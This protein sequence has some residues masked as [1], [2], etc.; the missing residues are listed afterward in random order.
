MATHYIAKDGND[1]TSD[2]TNVSTPWATYAALVADGISTGD[3]VLFKAGTYD[4][5]I[6]YSRSGTTHWLRP[7]TVHNWGVYPTGATV[8]FQPG[9]DREIL[10]FQDG[11]ASDAMTMQGI[12]FKKTNGSHTCEASVARVEFLTGSGTDGAELL[13]DQC[14]FIANEDEDDLTD[15]ALTVKNSRNMKLTITD[16]EF[17]GYDRR[18]LNITHARALTT[19]SGNLF[20][21]S[22]ADA[23]ATNTPIQLQKANVSQDVKLDFC[24]NVVKFERNIVGTTTTRAALFKFFQT[25]YV[26]DNSFKATRLAG[27]AALSDDTM[28]RI[29]EIDTSTST[30]YV[31]DEVVVTGNTFINDVHRGSC[32]YLAGETAI[33][34]GT[35]TV[36]YNEFIGTEAYAVDSDARLLYLSRTVNTTVE[37]NKFSTANDGIH[38]VECI[39]TDNKVNNNYFFK[40]ED[41]G[42][43]QTGNTYPIA[44]WFNKCKKFTA[45]NNVFEYTRDTYGT[46]F[47]SQANT[48]DGDNAT[49][50][51]TNNRY[52]YTGPKQTVGK[53]FTGVET[54]TYDAD[55]VPTRSGEVYSLDGTANNAT[56]YSST[57]SGNKNLAALLAEENTGKGHLLSNL[58][59]DVNKWSYA[60]SLTNVF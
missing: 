58:T 16:N 10:F 8:V 4:S 38:A 14:K 19:I 23:D 31:S 6:N 17:Y 45:D 48:G 2:G 11:I 49:H 51:F 13:I 50:E 44:C 5:E 39:G 34:T 41:E 55:N 42:T 25:T 20:D 15:S 32:L 56:L 22:A 37:H 60:K 30:N 35:Y 46:A 29:L 33:T 28:T 57:V 26:T 24:N 43:E 1:S 54:S 59:S 36:K 53:R 18:V 3:T 52:L 27:G 9:A 47:Y 21:I 12:Q 7:G 40:V